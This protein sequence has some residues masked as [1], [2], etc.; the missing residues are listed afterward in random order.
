MSNQARILNAFIRRGPSTVD[1]IEV[2][3]GLAHQVVSARAA[4]LRRT[5]SLRCTGKV[6]PTRYGRPARV[7]EA[8][9]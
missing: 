3:T 8:V 2:Y 5:G 9:Q 7:L 4:D 1:E 6:R